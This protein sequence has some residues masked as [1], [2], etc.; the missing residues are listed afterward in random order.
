[1]HLKVLQ[2]KGSVPT[3]DLLH[4]DLLA[5]MKQHMPA[6]AASDNDQPQDF[7]E[8]FWKQQLQAFS[9]SNPKSI[10]WHPLVVKWCLYLHHKSSGAYETLRKSGVIRLP[11]GRTLRD[12]RHF[13]PVCTGLS[14]A[15]DRQ[16]RDLAHKNSHLSKYVMIIVDEMYVKEGLV[17]NKSTGS[18]IG[19]VDLGDINNHFIDIENFIST[20]STKRPKRPLAKTLLVFMV[21]GAVTNFVFPY[22]LYPAKSPK[23]CDLFPILWDI[24]ERLTRNDFRVLAVTSDGASCNRNLFQMHMQQRKRVAQELCTRL[25]IYLACT[26]NIFIL[27]QILPTY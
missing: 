27:Y 15:T 11:S 2:Q 4:S 17:F 18:V 5:L 13:A 8:I 1:M 26:Q 23:G 6:P 7:K 3:D 25:R 19:F 10:K 12:Y 9:K 14:L 16:L 24:I 20:G 22:A 21:R